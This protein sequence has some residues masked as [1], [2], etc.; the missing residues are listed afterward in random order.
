VR[1]VD[2]LP[3]PVEVPV[4]PPRDEL[5]ER[6]GFAGP[7]LVFSG[8]LVPQKDL[9][10]LVAAVER[11]PGATLLLAGDGE[12]RARLDGRARLLGALPRP[13]VLELLRAAD[14]AVLSSRWENFPH[15]L[16]E[17]LAVGTPVVATAV[18]GVPEIVRDGEN[19]VLVPPG[20]PEA[21]ADGI[22]RALAERDRLASAAAASVKRFE[23]ER[24]YGELAEILERAAAS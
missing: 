6:H 3:N 20:D 9:D 21:L 2:V 10:T 12:E 4:L 18:G 19:G 16:V 8:R 24:I 11:V 17:A 13:Q 23:P 15:A 1:R 5:R 14:L 22:R 7:T